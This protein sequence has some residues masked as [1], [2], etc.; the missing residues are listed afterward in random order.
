MITVTV[1]NIPTITTVEANLVDS[2]DITIPLTYLSVSGNTLTFQV[3][4]GENIN[5][6]STDLTITTIL[7]L[8]INSTLVCATSLSI[9][10]IDVTF[11]PA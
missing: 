8:Y 2:T 1:N 3:D 10:E 5:T 9:V 6:T 7:I 11:P 4:F